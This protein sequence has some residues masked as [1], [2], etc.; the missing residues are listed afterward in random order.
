MRVLV[1]GGAG[2]I[3]SALIRMLLATD[4]NEVL[5]F[6][7]LTYAG[8]L[9]SLPGAE[10][11]QRYTFVHGNI[12][13]FEQ[14]SDAIKGFEPE[15][16]MHLAAETHV[17]RSID[18]SVKFVETNVLG[19]H[20]VLEASRKYW[21]QLPESSR[22]NF[23][24][25]HISTD[26]VF[27]S[28]QEGGFFT[29]KTSY[30]PSS[31]YSASKAASDH[32]VRAWHRTYGLPTIITNCSNN[33]GEYQ[34]PE[35]FIPLMIIKALN[36][37]ELPLYG[38]GLQV[39]D[40]LHVADHARALWLVARKGRVGDTYNI[41]GHDE[42]S[43]LEV[44]QSI[45]SYLDQILPGGVERSSL[46]RHV[47]DRPGH[48]RRYAIDASKI[49]CDLGWRPAVSFEAGLLKTVRWYIENE[50]WWRNVQ[51]N[52]YRGQRLGLS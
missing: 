11:N 49:E 2:F 23:I 38:D 52:A 13:D 10:V 27:G 20:V 33:Y 51:S 19:T 35:K 28:L 7:A 9:S 12:K 5:N 21:M 25:H 50:S 24:F 16:V 17:D 22:E 48:D 34:F 37:E 29:E 32:L 4:K 47:T 41:G 3:G 6:D 1:T 26:E 46:I 14:V 15:I 45:C 18:S 42:R 40:W 30:D 39:R 36:Y 31:P 43:N 8:S 44:A